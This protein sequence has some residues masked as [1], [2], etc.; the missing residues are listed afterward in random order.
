M[1]FV[2]DV[3]QSQGYNAIFV[4]IDCLT[5]YT[6]LI[7]CFMGEDHLTVKQ[8]ALL[9]FQNVVQDIGIPKSVFHNKNPKITSNSWQ[10]LWK[11]LG[12][13]TIAVSAHH[14]QADGQTD[15]MN[16]TIGQ[17]LHAHLLEKNQEHWP[18]Y[19]AITIMAINSTI[20]ARI[21]KAPFEIFYSENTLLIVD[22][23]LS[24]ESSINPNA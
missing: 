12:S 15:F 23:L 9:S 20:N 6:K 5:K 13:H 11:L 21:N 22:L 1:D 2:T 14:P 10:T 8:V 18:D 19:V 17:I 3:C 4:Y 16:H 7:P 24:K